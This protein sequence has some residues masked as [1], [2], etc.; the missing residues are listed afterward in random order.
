M[1]NSMIPFA[2]QGN[3]A[4]LKDLGG[5]LQQY[6]E[7]TQPEGGGDLLLRLNRRDGSWIYGPENIETETEARWAINPLSIMH[8]WVNWYTGDDRNEL[9]GEVMAPFTAPQIPQ[10]EAIPDGRWDR[11]VSFM[12]KCLTGEDEGMQVLYKVASVGGRRE[13]QRVVQE[14]IAQYGRDPENC[15]PV[16]LLKSDS[17]E[18]KKWGTT[19]TPIFAVQEWATMEGETTEADDAVEEAAAEEAHEREQ[20]AEANEHGDVDG[21]DAD[22]VAQRQRQRRSRSRNK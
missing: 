14:I 5:G 10:P 21:T 16:V 3:L 17:Y 7:H 4:S 20:E 18:H 8:G 1:S 2:G 22:A 9:L 19:F 15:V 12:L 13:H 6:A 11:Q